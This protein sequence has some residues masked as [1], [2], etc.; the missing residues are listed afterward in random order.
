[1]GALSQPTSASSSALNDFANAFAAVSQYT[2]TVTL[3]EQNGTRIQ[4]AVYDY[5]F[6]KPASVTL[7]VIS[8]ASAGD[9]LVWNGGST[10]V[11]HRG[12]GLFSVFKKTFS[13]HDPATTTIRGSSIDELGFGAI[14]VHA[15]QTAG[16]LSSRS[17]G[18]VRGEATEAITLLPKSATLDGGYT[19]EILQLSTASRLPVR[20]LGYEG[21]KLVREIDFSN[22]KLQR[23][24]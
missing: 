13:L 21:S 23:S 5:T 11:A 10:V 18:A 22:L 1:M 2:A 20:V 6:Q 3:F 7:H 4:R 19:R 9:T 12:S 17:G 14:L 15:S 16:I 8:G 24:T